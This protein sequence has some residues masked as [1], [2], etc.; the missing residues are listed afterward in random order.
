MRGGCPPTPLTAA[1]SGN[2]GGFACCSGCMRA[3]V[4]GELSTEESPSPEHRTGVSLSSTAS[5]RRSPG[6]LTRSRRKKKG[7][8]EARS[9]MLGCHVHSILVGRQVKPRIRISPAAAENRV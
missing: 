2:A 5:H 3:W 7:S 9:G 4:G 6:L 8:H 1:C